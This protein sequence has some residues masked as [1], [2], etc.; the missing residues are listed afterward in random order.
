LK[1]FSQEQEVIR[2]YLLGL[3]PPEESLAIEERLL[4]GDGFYE[5]L[6]IA[7][8][9]LVDE[10][11]RGGLT[12]PERQRFTSHFLQPPERQQ[13]LRFARALRRYV[14]LAAKAEPRE[15]T[16]AEELPREVPITA[17][18]PRPKYSGFLSFR[19]PVVS[20]GLL[21][22]M[23]LIIGGISWALFNNWKHQATQ[24]AGEVVA[25]V[26]TPGLTRDA[27][28]TKRIAL[29]P[30]IGL[31][32]LQ[33]QVAKSDYTS[34]RVVMLANDRSEIL[35]QANLPIQVLAG[36]RTVVADVP[37]DSLIPG[38]Y[39]IKLS[40]Q[41]ANAAFEDVATYQLRIAR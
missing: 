21:T 13:K 22:A 6:L 32:R 28:E 12:E 4:T 39:Q 19:N 26:L 37:A 14:D 25:V 3:T 41:V 16:T 36:S 10:Y 24:P 7:E 5:E 2:Q 40:G 23:L 1:H 38:D 20:Y 30:G 31:L 11:L 17:R 8:D 27:G 15:T 34:Y 33:L 29:R 9:E 18:R 35:N